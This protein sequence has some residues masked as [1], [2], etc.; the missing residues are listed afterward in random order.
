[1]KICRKFREFVCRYTSCHL[2][3]AVALCACSRQ[4]EYDRQ[5]A[6]AESVIEHNA[7]SALLLLST[8]PDV[9]KRGTEA[10]RALYDLLCT[11]ALYKLDRDN[12]DSLL[13]VISRSKHFFARTGDLLRQ[14]RSTYYH[15]M[16]CYYHDDHD[17]AVVL[18]KEGERLAQ[19]QRDTTFLSKYYE[20][21]CM[22][23]DRSGNDSLFLAYEKKF[24]NIAVMLKD[25][26]SMIRSLS[27]TCCAYKKL[28]YTD[29]AY[30]ATLNVFQLVDKIREEDKAFVLTN[31]AADMLE[32]GQIS[33]AKVFLQKAL[34]LSQRSNTL[35]LL[36]D[37]YLAEKD[38]AMAL[39]YWKQS[40]SSATYKLKVATLKSIIYVTEHNR[41]TGPYVDMLVTATDSF[42]IE[43]ER[44]AI[45][46]IQT[47]FDHQLLLNKMYKILLIGIVGI[48]LCILM[49]II[50]WKVLKDK[51]A[52]ARFDIAAKEHQIRAI[53]K[54][55][56]DLKK[57]NSA[58][59]KQIERLQKVVSKKREEM[60]GQIARGKLIY[61]SI[62]KT[63]KMALTKEDEICL[64]E[65]F[66]SV[67]NETYLAWQEKYAKL[68]QR[69]I[70]YLILTDMGLSDSD[71]ASVLCVTPNAIRT[72]KSRLKSTLKENS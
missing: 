37:V 45:F 43:R 15:A 46:E 67:K 51:L 31:A 42:Y 47:K 53:E 59:R 7:D 4:A 8:I 17:S 14:E 70:T 40:L 52:S 57:D 26:A 39:Q 25:T 50:I 61:D 5:L 1:M 56:S 21:L 62:G 22:V 58:E 64:I 35:S 2:L 6:A 20:S 69:T 11:E 41:Q 71:I 27:G 28:G 34:T 19:Q 10:S 32:L 65:Y 63:N 3:I 66:C 38:T 12:P 49:A 60:N 36:G 24:F 16:L 18:L 48:I 54:Q 29:S 33:S 30:H 13:P 44:A 72:A 55:I 23:N 68:T 9:L